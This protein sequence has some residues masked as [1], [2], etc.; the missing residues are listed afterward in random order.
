MLIFATPHAR[1]LIWLGLGDSGQVNVQPITHVDPSSVNDVVAIGMRAESVR[2]VDVEQVGTINN[3]GR[4][5]R[6]RVELRDGRRRVVIDSLI[7]VR[8]EIAEGRKSELNVDIIIPRKDLKS[9][10]GCQPC[11]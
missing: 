8:S 2:R 1:L 9:R 11:N 4:V 10:N 3:F 5:W 6:R 7:V